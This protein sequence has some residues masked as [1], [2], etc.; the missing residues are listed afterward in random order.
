MKTRKSYNDSTRKT[1]DSH[2]IAYYVKEVYKHRN[3]A[4]LTINECFKAFLKS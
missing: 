3:K 2:A 4:Y 1:S